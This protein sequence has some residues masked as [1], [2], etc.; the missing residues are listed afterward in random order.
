ML[1]TNQQSA[2]LTEPGIGALYDPAAEIT[3]QLA[4]KG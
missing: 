1:V 2:E 4:P 3:P